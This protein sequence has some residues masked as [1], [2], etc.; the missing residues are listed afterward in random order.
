MRFCSLLRCHSCNFSHGQ[1][2]LKSKALSFVQTRARHRLSNTYYSRTPLQQK[3]KYFRI[4]QLYHRV[5]QHE[6]YLYTNFEADRTNHV[7]TMTNYFRIIQLY[8]RVGQHERYL[9]TNF[10]ADR[11]NHVRTMTN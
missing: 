5:G 10:E 8:H 11:T 7:R 6:R 1:W 2:P 3:L 4:I 9:Y